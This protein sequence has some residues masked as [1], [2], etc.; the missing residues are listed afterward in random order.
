[1]AKKDV[2]FEWL[3]D[4]QKAFEE[5]VLKFTTAPTHRHFNHSREVIIKTDASDFVSAAVLSQRDNEGVLHPVAFF[6]KK[7]SP[8]ECNYDIY[9]K[10]LMAIIKALEE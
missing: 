9:D 2:P 4:Q 7:R 3:E 1:L 6:S 8:E 10:E 5:M